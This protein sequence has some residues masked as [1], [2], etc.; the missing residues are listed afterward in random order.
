MGS[1]MR[2]HIFCM[3]SWAESFK[4]ALHFCMLILDTVYLCSTWS[5][6][7]QRLD[8]SSFIIFSGQH[9][10]SVTISLQEFVIREKN[11]KSRWPYSSTKEKNNSNLTVMVESDWPNNYKN[12]NSGGYHQ[13][14]SELLNRNFIFS[15]AF[16]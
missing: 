10:H 14:D 2:L 15:V 9:S 12:L 13:P 3:V 6:I 8:Q 5:F 16:L 7:L 1:L 4:M 11:E